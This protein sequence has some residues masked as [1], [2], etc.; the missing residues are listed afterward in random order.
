MILDVLKSFIVIHHGKI[1]LHKYLQG[2]FVD[3]VDV[4]RYNGFCLEVILN[5]IFASLETHSRMLDAAKPIQ[6]SEQVK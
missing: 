2:G 3:D 4:P 5:P 1:Y 6:S